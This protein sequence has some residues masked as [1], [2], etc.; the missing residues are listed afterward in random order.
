VV[1]RLEKR[2]VARVSD[3]FEKCVFFVL[4]QADR[5]LEGAPFSGRFAGTGRLGARAFPAN[6]SDSA[7]EAVWL[8]CSTGLDFELF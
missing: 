3:L 4:G 5:L 6:F 2:Q 7:S 1:C 8:F